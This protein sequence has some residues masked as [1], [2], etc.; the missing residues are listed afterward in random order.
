MTYQE[1]QIIDLISDDITINRVKKF[2]IT[3]YG[4]D[5]NNENIACH[6]INYL[7]HFY[8]KVPDHWDTTDSINLLKRICVN[9]RLNDDNE[10]IILNSL[11]RG[12][13]DHKSHIVRGKDFYNL[14]WNKDL[15][16]IKEYSFFKAS[17]TNL[18]DMKKVIT[19]IRK[20]YN[21]DPKSKFTYLDKDK[22][23]INLDRPLEG[24]K[25]CDSNLYES[26]LHPIIRFIH[27]RNIDPTGWVS[28]ETEDKNEINIFKDNDIKE[29]TCK[30]DK[31]QKIDDIQTS[32]YKIASFDIECDSL[33]GD[34]PMAKKTL[35]KFSASIYDSLKII[36]NKMPNNLEMKPVEEDSDS[37]DDIIEENEYFEDILINLIQIGF[38]K[39]K[40]SDCKSYYEYI[41]IEEI[42]TKDNQ[43]IHPVFIDKIINK[44][45]EIPN[46]FTILNE[47]KNK[48]KDRDKIITEINEIFEEYS[49]DEND[50]A[51]ELLGDPIIQIGTVFHDYGTNEWYR[52]ILV[53]G[54]EDNMPDKKICDNLDD[55]SIDVVHCKDEKEL[56]IKWMELI[57]E[58]DPDF[59]TGYNIFGFDFRYIKDRVDIFFPCPKYASG[60]DMCN[61]WGHHDTCPKSTFYN[62]GKIDQGETS[63]RNKIC[64]F[65]SQDLNSS[66]LGENKLNYFTMD[67][68]I[69][70]DIQKEVE[71]GHNL[72]S[73]KLDNVASHFMRG[74]LKQIEGNCIQV[75]SVGHLKDGDYVS[76]RLHSNIGE[77]LYKDG[78]KIKIKNIVKLHITLEESMDINLDDYHKIEWCLNKDDISPQDIFDK[79]KDT[80]PNG[81]KG[82]AEVAK[83]CIQDCELCINLLLLL[84]IIPN[85]LAMANVSFVPASYIF[86]RGQGV[87]VTSVVTKECSKRHTR[88]PELIKIPNLNDYV[89]MAKNNASNED[90]IQ[91]IIDDSDWRKP[92]P[93]ELD[94]WLTLIMKKNDYTIPGYEGAIVLDPTPGIYLDE[95]VAV[96]DYASLYPSSI[97]EKN[98]SHETYIDD[99]TLIEELK[100]VKDKDYHEIKYDNWIYKGKGSG[101]TIEKIIN[102]EEPIKTCQFLTKDFM[103]RNNMEPKGI[104]PSV[105]D[106]LLSARSATK[107]RM[108]N[109][110]NEFKKK[111]LDGLQLA[112]KVTANSVYG[113]LGAKTS[114]I[115]KLELA[116]CTT[117][118]GRSRIEDAD[119]GV[120]KWAEAKGYP[121]PEVVY[122]DTDSVF[123]KFSRK[124]KN[125]K[126]LEGKEA[127]K[128]CIQCGIEAGDYITKGEL[129][130]EDKIV[131]H[132]PLLHS[133]Q[134][135]EYE[136][137]F[138]PFI[139]I[140]KKR[141][142]GDKYEFEPEN[143]KRTAMGIVLKRR[144]NAPIVKYVFGH[145]IEKIMI[146]KDFLATVEWLKQTL[147]EIRE[148]KFPISHFVISKSL[149]GYYKNPQ[150][151]AHKV[152]ADRMA[153]RD[154]GNKP[155]ANDRIPYA[156]IE[157]DDERKIKKYRMKTVKKP[158]GFYKKTIKEEIGI[159]KGGPRKGQIKTRN[160][161]IDDKDRPKYKNSKVIDKECPIYEKKK[162]I[163]QGNRIEHIDYIKDKNLKLDY[164]FYITNQIMN[165]VKQVLDL[166]MDPTETEKLFQK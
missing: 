12:T 105:L 57:K 84:D 91:Q 53:I 120:K 67:G 165:P 55:L 39:K 13:E 129:K 29:F 9:S 159:F 18:G 121:E 134:D 142:T 145:V 156:Y 41:S 8:L 81:A 66:A 72:D 146:E 14:S 164:E 76:F 36:I 86:L 33:T 63:H 32:N 37:D 140:S 56:L 68:R 112:Y 141:Y 123:V 102:E 161:T 125:G 93:W 160:K 60:K 42:Q 82:R 87:K 11:I 45:K 1:F 143:P 2:C 107:K 95:P 124:D 99:P 106:H 101:D 7:P 75:D 49:I 158:D 44:I 40:I 19:E 27:E 116:A 85:N 166:E 80:G 115:F 118:V 150:S 48:N 153:E 59:I 94:K 69:L 50:Q 149:R 35:K 139:L 24:D 22:E 77:E 154:P 119:Q 31:I 104:I 155:K 100:W 130:L 4:K 135:L 163:L 128:H 10:I 89:K 152:L 15:N 16:N 114:T 126:Q 110:P 20:F 28:C 144:D 79:Q 62:L 131:Y 70:F 30:W 109:E 43:S 157:V 98:I 71:K 5:T 58:Q 97:I 51:I 148:G 46:F 52:N 38:H 133:P 54:P 6:I 74:K 17:F 21:N 137:T 127:L 26:S 25:I 90:I 47:E 111:V 3:I 108:K 138:W 34:F 113:Q 65:K 132:K 78:H 117:S 96:L 147:Q 88:V 23:W 73:Y 162:P 83:Y 103:E 64:S 136:K 92:N 122:G 151:I 61:K